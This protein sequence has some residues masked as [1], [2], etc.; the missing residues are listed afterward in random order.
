[1]LE[2]VKSVMPPEFVNRF[3]SILVFHHLPREV[4][5]DIAEVEWQFM[6]ER[7]RSRGYRLSITPEAVD[8]A[9]TA[10]YDPDFG[11]RHLQ[12]NIEKLFLEALVVHPPGCYETRAERRVIHWYPVQDA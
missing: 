4:I 8:L 3:D 7:V 12:R 5:R 2:V 10:G 6:C 1:M 9:A 11:A